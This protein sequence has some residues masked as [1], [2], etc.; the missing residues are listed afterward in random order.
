MSD[1]IAALLDEK[2]TDSVFLYN[3]DDDLVFYIDPD[4]D[5]D[6]DDPIIPEDDDE[7]MPLHILCGF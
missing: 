7:I 1:A 3:E 6:N 5:E 2:N 4:D